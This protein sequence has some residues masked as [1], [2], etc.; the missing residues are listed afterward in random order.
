[1]IWYNKQGKPI[2]SNTANE[3]LGDHNYV[4]VKKTKVKKNEISTVWLG[5][6][7]SFNNNDGLPLIFETIVFPDC[8]DMDR[9]HTLE[10]AKEGHERMVKKYKIK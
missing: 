2:D 4:V 3:L 10:E 6:D 9:Y 5:L 7:H 8:E 1:M